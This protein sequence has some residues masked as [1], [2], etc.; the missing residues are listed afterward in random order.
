MPIPPEYLAYTENVIKAIGPK[1][2]PRVKEALPILLRHIHAGVIEAGVTTE[3]WLACI[4]LLAEAGKMTHDTRAE[5]ILCSDIIGVSSLVDMME[6]AR[7]ASSTPAT[8]SAVLGPFYRPGIPVQPN[9]TSISNHP[10][11]EGIPTHVFGK[12]KSSLTGL[13]IAGAQIDI[14]EDAPDGFYDSQTPHKA[15][16]GHHMRGKFVADS[17]GRYSAMVYK[18]IP[19]PIPTDGPGGQLLKMMDRHPMR[20]AH[21]HFMISAPGFQ[22]LVT[23]VFDRTSDYLTDDAVFAVKN[24]LVVDFVPAKSPAPGD[25]KPVLELEYDFGLAELSKATAA[26]SL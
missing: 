21:I 19:Y 2:S 16:G 13:P 22:T 5:M 17:E 3:E 1:A 26:S 23:Q 9:G 6:H 8:P 18:P 15:G 24:V 14:W 20:P 4:M 12:V 25:A 11:P 7:A 10:E